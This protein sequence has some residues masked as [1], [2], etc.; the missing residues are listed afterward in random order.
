VGVAREKE[1]LGDPEAGVILSQISHH[2][3]VHNHVTRRHEDSEDHEGLFT[4]NF[5]SF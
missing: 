1:T 2:Y 4:K 3:L 5:V